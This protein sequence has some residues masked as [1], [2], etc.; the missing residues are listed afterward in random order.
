MT[1]IRSDGSQ[2]DTNE[3]VPVREE[4]VVQKICPK[5]TTTIPK[6]TSTVPAPTTVIPA[7]TPTTSEVQ[8]PSESSSSYCSSCSTTY[9]SL[10]SGGGRRGRRLSWL[11]HTHWL[12]SLE[13]TL[14]G[15]S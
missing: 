6:P 4:E 15:K 1:N 13:T 2:Y 7:P 9:Y 3:P 5:P 11:K 8:E 14:I 10:P 12:Y